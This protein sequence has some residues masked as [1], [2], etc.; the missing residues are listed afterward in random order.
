MSAYVLS[1][2]DS[3]RQRTCFLG[4]NGHWRTRTGIGGLGRTKWTENVDLENIQSEFFSK[5]NSE[6][7]APAFELVLQRGSLTSEIA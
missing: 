4:H 6:G 5:R 2:L 7:R 3:L 1:F